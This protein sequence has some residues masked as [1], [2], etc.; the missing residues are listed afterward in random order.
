MLE[1]FF[2]GGGEGSKVCPKFV[3]RWTQEE[4]EWYWADHA[5]VNAGR[6]YLA[7][8][9]VSS[10]LSSTLLKRSAT[11]EQWPGRQ[12]GVERD[13]PHSHTSLSLSR[14]FWALEVCFQGALAKMSACNAGGHRLYIR[15]VSRCATS[16]ARNSKPKP[17]RSSLWLTSLIMQCV[18]FVEWNFGR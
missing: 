18:L 11:L 4:E 5:N 1:H 17:C 9:P 10:S 3:Q 8:H 12:K 15:A 6:R 14:S 7:D 2:T 16:L 13:Q